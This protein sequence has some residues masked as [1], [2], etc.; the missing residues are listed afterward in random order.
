MINAQ[1]LPYERK[2]F[3][4]LLSEEAVGLHYDKHHLGYV[5]KLNEQIKDTKLAEKDL[6][7]IIKISSYYEDK[8]VFNNAAQIWNHDFYWQSLAWDVVTPDDISL[9]VCKIFESFDTFNNAVVNIGMRL[10][11]NGWIW[12]VQDNK[13][14]KLHLTA[15][16]N[17]DNPIIFNQ[18]PL[19]AIDIWEHA[20]YVDYKNDRKAYLSN[21][22][23][24]LNWEFANKN[25]IS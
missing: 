20:Y 8:S 13:T 2:L 6:E 22:V 11:G 4:P 5:K 12:L 17:A 19:L 3:K 15:T 21:I 14:K 24:C 9:K 25:L 7:D 10:F 1:P 18:T 23:K 16:S